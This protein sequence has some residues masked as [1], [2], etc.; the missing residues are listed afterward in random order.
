MNT[1][2]ANGDEARRIFRGA[3]KLNC[4][5][6][7]LTA[8]K[9]T[10]RVREEDVVASATLGKGRAPGGECGALWAARMLLP[11][12]E[13]QRELERRFVAVTGSTNC[14]RIRELRRA[15]CH[16]CV[17]SAGNALAGLISSRPSADGPE[18]PH[19][20]E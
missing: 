14:R 4:A 18:K 6:A 20:E 16:E 3:G 9:P 13:A 1:G 7:I 15:S 5:Q 2:T 11:D 10:G 8:F 19:T 17:E 12:D